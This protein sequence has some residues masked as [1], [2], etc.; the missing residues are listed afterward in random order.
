MTFDDEYGLSS[1]AVEEDEQATAYEAAV[2]AQEPVYGDAAA[3]FR[4]ALSGNVGFP[5]PIRPYD[6]GRDEGVHDP[7]STP[8]I[9][10]GDAPEDLGV[11]I[12]VPR[13]VDADR[14]RRIVEDTWEYTYGLGARSQAR[15]L[16]RAARKGMWDDAVF[17]AVRAP[18]I[19]GT[20]ALNTARSRLGAPRYR[21]GFHVSDHEVYVHLYRGEDHTTIN[22]QGEPYHDHRRLVTKHMNLH[23][24]RVED[25]VEELGE[26]LD[27]HGIV[28][29][30]D[31]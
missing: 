20:A 1:V 21:C 7:V 12:H 23:A 14:F 11:D 30:T 28:P 13:R 8:V 31:I 5:E 24:G 19:L 17:A 22:V 3:T 6:A 15:D 10:P 2:D 4:E 18:A 26:A 9:A 27:D 29:P 25:A 16:Y